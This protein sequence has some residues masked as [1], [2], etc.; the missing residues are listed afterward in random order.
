MDNRIERQRQHFNCRLERASKIIDP[1][2]RADYERD[3]VTDEQEAEFS[4]RSG[5]IRGKIVGLGLEGFMA[6]IIDGMN[7]TVSRAWP[8]DLIFYQ[9][10]TKKYQE[11]LR[12]DTDVLLEFGLDYVDRWLMYNRL[13]SGKRFQ[14]GDNQPKSI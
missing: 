3:L 8:S 9:V 1:T 10:S 6:D 12:A 14:E 5:F 11:L 4:Y 2:L 13:F 7:K